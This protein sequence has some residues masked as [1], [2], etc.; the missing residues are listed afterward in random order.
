MSLESKLEGRMQAGI[1]VTITSATEDSSMLGGNRNSGRV[2]R[3]DTKADSA[4]DTPIEAMNLDL[5]AMVTTMATMI[6]VVLA[7]TA[8]AVARMAMP[9]PGR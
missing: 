2:T 8:M 6:G 5:T 4:M 1:L 7:L 9:Q 3:R